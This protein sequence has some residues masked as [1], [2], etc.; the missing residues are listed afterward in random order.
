MKKPTCASK[1]DVL[2]LAILQYLNGNRNNIF[3]SVDF[4]KLARNDEVQLQKEFMVILY[5]KLAVIYQKHG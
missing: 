5:C 4:S 2:E 1:C 3:E